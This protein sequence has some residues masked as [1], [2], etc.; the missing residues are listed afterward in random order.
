M[1][2]ASSTTTTTTAWRR[3]TPPR[4]G[5][6]QGD[7]RSAL[8]LLV[9]A[10]LFVRPAELHPALYGLPIY[11]A[12]ILGCL[13]LSY[14]LAAAELSVH[15]LAARPVNACVV[16]LLPVIVLSRAVRGELAEA[17]E[18]GTEFVKVLLYYVLLVSVV[19]TPA[20][21]R[22]FL[23][24]L[25]VFALAITMLAVPHYHGIIDVPFMETV[26]SGVDDSG[27]AE[28]MVRRLGSTG[29]FGDPNDLSLMLVMAMS[30]CVYQIV[31]LK[32]WYWTAPLALFG[33]ALVLTHSRGGFLAML[34]ALCVLLWQRLGRKALPVA[35]LVLPAAFLLFAGRQ[36]DLEGA[37]KGEGTA[38]TR[39]GLWSEGLL[40]FSHAP[41]FGIG[42]GRYADLAGHVAHNSFIHG[43]VELGLAGGTLF[44]GAFYIAV[45][46]L[47]R[48]GGADVPAAPM[49]DD[50]ARLRPY[51]LTIVVGYA[52]GLTSLSCCYTIPTYTVL[53]LASLYVAQAE[54]R[55]G[56]PVVRVSVALAQRVA[57]LGAAFVFVA[58]AGA[59]A[60]ARAGY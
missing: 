58:L 19:D 31:E 15:R 55:L 18:F 3:L 42:V 23:T 27:S 11:E 45:A 16:G 36:T 8:F 5:L 41:A 17:V 56:V 52:A 10:L 37:L 26:Q 33:H 46:A 53:G 7:V 57:L 32:R 51:V 9:N 20:R 60:L 43:Y 44:L 59:V 28:S 2:G 49:G 47:V 54:A 13:V 12:V 48:L 30:I 35:A 4:L 39:L 24:G 34:T 6:D 50:L 40:H 14:P 38:G 1:Q 29:L 22:R 25:G 21:L